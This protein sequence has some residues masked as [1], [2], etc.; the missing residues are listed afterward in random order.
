MWALPSLPVPQ[1]PLPNQQKLR[2][3]E[4]AGQQL[5]QRQNKLRD[6]SEFLSFVHRNTTAWIAERDGGMPTLTD[7]G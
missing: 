5:Q 1:L 2:L 6:I 3:V 7:S 4:G